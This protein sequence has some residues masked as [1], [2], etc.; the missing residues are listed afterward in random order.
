MA[1]RARHRW[2]HRHL[3]ALRGLLQ[4]PYGQPWDGLMRR[5]CTQCSCGDEGNHV[6]NF[7]ST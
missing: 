4:R 3:V 2:R 7:V 5:A 6:G 1:W